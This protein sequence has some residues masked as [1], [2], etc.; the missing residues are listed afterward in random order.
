MLQSC[1]PESGSTI[2][3]EVMLRG[4][5][6]HARVITSYAVS[7]GGRT[8]QASLEVALAGRHVRASAR[9]VSSQAALIAALQEAAA[10]LDLNLPAPWQLHVR[11]LPNNLFET[12]ISTGSTRAI[13][14]AVDYIVATVTA[15]EQLLQLTVTADRRS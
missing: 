7:L 1:P 2:T 6:P 5:E 13:G 4:R 15:L 9:G 12:T 11:I 3:W 14:V 10:Q 8:L